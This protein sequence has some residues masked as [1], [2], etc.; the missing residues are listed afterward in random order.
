[1]PTL[2]SLCPTCGKPTPHHSA[3]FNS[4]QTDADGRVHQEMECAICKIS[5]K[6]YFA[7]GT[8]EFQENLE[9][10]NDTD[11]FY[12]GADVKPQD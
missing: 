8:N 11:A 12:E 7:Q 9:A 10:P 3:G 2:M 1:M 5:T 4:K 6:V